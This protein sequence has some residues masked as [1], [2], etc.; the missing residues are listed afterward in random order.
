MF[1]LA[2]VQLQEAF[3]SDNSTKYENMDLSPD[4]K[5]RKVAKGGRGSTKGA[6]F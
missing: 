5:R 3:S 2:D 6:R 4:A 1:C